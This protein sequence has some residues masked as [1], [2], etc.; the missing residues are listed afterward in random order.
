[1]IIFV[2]HTSLRAQPWMPAK[3]TV[4]I[5]Y[6]EALER[7]YQFAE[8]TDDAT[9]EE[10]SHSSG[11]EAKEDKD[12]LFEC[13]NYYWKSHLD[14]D[15]Y[16]VPPVQT[17][18]NWQEYISHQK[19]Q[20]ERTT[21]SVSDWV[22]QG[23]STCD[24]GY[25][26]LGRINKVAFDPIDSNTF[27]VG[28]AGSNAWKTSDGG[29]SWMPMYDFLPMQ[30][31]SD[32]AVNPQNRNTIYIATGDGD[33]GDAYSSGV[34]VSHNAGLSWSTTGL[35]WLPSSYISTHSIL[36][37]PLD[38]TSMM[39]ASTN[40]LYKSNNS[41][42]SWTNVMSNNFK[43]IIYNPSDTA[44][45]YGTMYT[46]TCA[47]IM[48]SIDG[49]YTWNAVTSLREAQRINVAV[50][51][52]APSIV[53]AIVSNNQSGLAG[54]Y[55]SS[56]NGASFI[57]VYINDTFCNNNLLGY[58]LGLP[59]TSCG[60]Q[61]WYDLCIAVNPTDPNQVTVGGVNTYFSSDGGSSWSLAN[62]WYG[63][64]SG[65]ETVHADK[66]CLAYNPLSGA[67]FETCDGGV[68]KNYGPVTEPWTD[69]TNGITIT[70]F[71]RNAVDNNV[72]FCIGGAQDNG[73]KM[74][75]GGSTI[76]LTGGDG[77][78]PL[79]N[80]G[81]PSNMW[82][83]SYQNGSVSMT[84][85]GG[86]TYNSITDIIGESGAWVTPYVLHPTDPATLLLGYKKIYVTH[87][88]GSSWSDL[89]PVLDT[90]S[91]LDRI[92]IANTN[93]NYVYACLYDNNVGQPFIYHTT[94]FG[95]TWNTIATPFSSYISDLIIDPKNENR[96]WVTCPWYGITKVWSYNLLTHL[97]SNQ[98]GSLPDV[99]VN[100]IVIDSSTGTRY[101]GTDAAVFYR[102]TTMLNWAL[103]NNNLPTVHVDDLH[104]NY[105]T[106]ELWAAT[107]GR[108]MWKSVKHDHTTTGVL[109]VFMTQN[110]R[111]YPNPASTQIT[112][113]STNKLINNISIT[114]M[115]GQN[116]Y[117]SSYNE[118]KVT[119]DI[120]ALP[121]GVYFVKTNG[122]D[123]KKFVKD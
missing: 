66:H 33:A 91:F 26:G 56:D 119:I 41:G 97:W 98:N 108:G 90:N 29:N 102:D 85:D 76:D 49:G 112:I 10:Q 51:T 53:K 70:E 14:K 111:L 80:Y 109:P 7:Y 46:D 55:S 58:D 60:G 63:G 73:T 95:A 114:N 123:V 89:S 27:Y 101:V 23:P 37:N 62:Q 81:D 61:G 110:I 93:P 48:R 83:T 28:S 22:F 16:M 38:T 122:S 106:N 11:R 8:K 43:Q 117:S 77:M 15:G 24:H 20:G 75:D 59:T 45:V 42:V 13:W 35:S 84:N 3:T 21:A 103:Y 1:M 68:Y 121:P 78:Q 9:A 6:A 47:Q 74:V 2:A 44:I 104:I 71:Y 69:L 105:T 116:V 65:V 39:L 100:C 107:F 19:A 94:D 34:I 5:R 120:S 88:N 67:L 72:T 113:Q 30:G 64:V 115:V 92:A 82:Y 32:I 25:S 18:R 87:D 40:G 36:I 57:P 4:P 54:I 12:H 17:V 118:N 52:A 79:I 99:P 96:I 31:V 50:C 86:A